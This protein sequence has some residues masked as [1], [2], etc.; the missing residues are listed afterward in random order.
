MRLETAALHWLL[1]TQR[2][3]YACCERPPRGCIGQPDIIGI[4]RDRKLTEIE[5]KRSISDFRANSLK[6]HVQYREVMMH[7]WPN[8][9]YFCVPVSLLPKVKAILPAWAGLLVGGCN[10]SEPYLNIVKVA[11][12]NRL[13][14]KLSTKEC[15]QMA[16]CMAN[17]LAAVEKRYDNVVQEWKHGRDISQVEYQI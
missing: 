8:Q 14:E 12:P 17:H 15:V 11:P 6:Q 9:F 10:G 16:R 3:H 7:L 2:C 13:S 4:T 5:V 1:Y